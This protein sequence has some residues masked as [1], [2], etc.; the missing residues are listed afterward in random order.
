MKIFGVFDVDVIYV[1]PAITSAL[2]AL[3]GSGP[4]PLRRFGVPFAISAFALGYG[5]PLR[6]ILSFIPMAIFTLGYGDDY[7]KRLGVLY[8]PYIT[9]LGLLY[10]LSQFG[11]CLHFGGWNVLL[12]FSLVSS[13]SFLLG[14]VLSKSK[15]IPWK[16]AELTTG[17]MIGFTACEIIRHT[18]QV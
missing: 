6:F 7:F 3:G 14:M 5:Y 16:I 10:G 9:F 15:M 8:W 18:V 2:W 17:F 11:L 13:V 4:K 1:L 12:L